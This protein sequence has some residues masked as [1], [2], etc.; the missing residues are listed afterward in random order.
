MRRDR[1]VADNLHVVFGTGPVGSWVARTLVERGAAVRAV[2]RSG[3]RPDFVPESVE[4]VAAELSDE[5]QAV[6][7]A[8]G[9]SV[10]YQALNP[11]YHQWHDLFPGLQRSALAAAKAA[12][13]R[14]VAIDNLYMY[15]SSVGP[16]RERTRVAPASKKG[17]LRE[18]MAA[19][20]LA[21]H[22]RGDVHAT[23]LRS[24]DYYGPGVTGSALGD[25]VFPPILAGKP[26]EVLGGADIPHAYAYIE[27]V[28]KAAIE[29]GTHDQALGRVWITPHAPAPTQRQVLDGV[30]ALTGREPKYATVTP[31]KMRLAGLFAPGA[32]EMVEMM[33]EFTAPFTVDSSAIED[34][35]G[36]SATPL[37]DGLERTVAWY[38]GREV[39][40]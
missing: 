33:Y 20:V 18:R 13:A 31:I 28:A 2:N 35:F 19:D 37:D 39:T 26:G 15:D 36:L 4:V 3:N 10:V 23:I 40:E 38:R 22:E 32:R 5:S 9:A 29:L 21:A 12:G 27:D 17:R 16:I 24:S 30:F 8:K 7:A 11:P 6:R 1:A 14:Y 25:R 34:A